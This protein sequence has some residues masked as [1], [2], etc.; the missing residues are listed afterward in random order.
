MSIICV[1]IGGALLA[2]GPPG[3]SQPLGFFLILGGLFGYA[4]S[5]A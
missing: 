5:R 4:A 2:W 3:P 1:L